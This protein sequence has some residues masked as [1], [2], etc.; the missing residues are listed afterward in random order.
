MAKRKTKAL[1]WPGT[2][3]PREKLVEQ[4]AQAL[5]DNE[6]LAIFLRTGTR[7][8]NVI[9]LSEYLLKEFGSLYH[10]MSAN[11]PSFC[12]KPG[13][14]VTKYAQLQ[15]AMELSRRFFATRLAR[16][17]ALQ[18]PQDTHRYLQNLISHRDREV[19]IVMFLDNRHR[20]ICHEEMFTGTI[21]SVEVHPREVVRAALRVNAAALILA[22]NHPSGLAEPSEADKIITERI[23]QA[24]LLVDV[25][26]L[27]HLVIGRGESVSFAER[28]WL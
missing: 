17:N 8:M 1:L 20:V 19:F 13:L 10:L 5:S 23:I 18:N 25:R 3:A 14:G 7:G 24:C 28:G 9:V 12:E 6:L 16:D 2:L 4:G 27:D 15:A 11:Y 21:S 26:V 22:H